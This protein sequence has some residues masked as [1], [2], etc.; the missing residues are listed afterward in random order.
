MKNETVDEFNKRFNK[1]FCIK[2]FIE[3]CNNT[4]Q[5]LQLCCVSEDIDKLPPDAD[6]TQVFYNHHKLVDIRKKMIKGEYVKECEPCISREKNN[7][8]S[9]R[10]GFT[11]DFDQEIVQKIWQTKEPILSSVDIK[12]GN[13]CNQACVM[14]SPGVSSLIAKEQNKPIVDFNENNLNRLKT[15]ASSIKR[16]KTTGGEPLLQ[17]AFEKSIDLL[18][19]HGNPSDTEFV[20]VTNST[21]DISKHIDKLSNFRRINLNLSLDAVSEQ[22]YK[23][24]RYPG[25]I[26]K[27]LNNHKK[28]FNKIEELK[29]NKP[30]ILCRA[31]F[32][33]TMHAL[34]WHDLPEIL[35]YI[36]S[37]WVSESM[38]VMIDYVHDP[39]HLNPSLIDKDVLEEYAQKSI[40][41]IDNSN[42]PDT[43]KQESIEMIKL[44]VE[45]HD[46][47]EDRDEKLSI[48]K[49]EIEYWKNIRS[50]DGYEIIPYLKQMLK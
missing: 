27:V 30:N 32:A 4:Q 42:F 39:D 3:F 36:N 2:P 44:I 46:D 50:M 20:V 7:S 16:F 29:N 13:I 41:I 6:V 37:I 26:K 9:S 49:Q 28:L 12:F 35:K 47:I 11:N 48:I 5:S 22:T 38:D 21:V 31:T 45:N 14:C 24:V 34:N 25:N 23:Y 18:L 15:V 8:I 33:I 43:I 1:S 10:T 40:S 19:E 17:P